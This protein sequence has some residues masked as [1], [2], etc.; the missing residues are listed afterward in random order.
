[1]RSSCVEFAGVRVEVAQ[2]LPSRATCKHRL[3]QPLHSI[4]DHFINKC[5]VIRVDSLLTIGSKRYIDMP[6]S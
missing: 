4:L 5:L 1:M 6:S 3:G 2:L